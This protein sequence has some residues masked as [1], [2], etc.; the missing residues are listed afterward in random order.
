MVPRVNFSYTKK[1][2]SFALSFIAGPVLESGLNLRT[3]KTEVGIFFAMIACVFLR[4]WIDCD[5]LVYEGSS[6][7]EKVR[8]H[9]MAL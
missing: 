4:H 7:L 5:C 8:T 1:S 6:G 9:F 3:K 2:F